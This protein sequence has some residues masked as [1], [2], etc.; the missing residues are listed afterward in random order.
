[1]HTPQLN[2]PCYFIVHSLAEEGKSDKEVRVEFFAVE[3][4][5]Q[6]EE[7]NLKWVEYENAEQYEAVIP[8]LFADLGL[9]TY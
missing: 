7:A 3:A 8:K 1:M 5:K 9:P 2:K 6:V 4:N